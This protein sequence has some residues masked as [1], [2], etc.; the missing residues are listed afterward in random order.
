MA[1]LS[2]TIARLPL[3]LRKAGLLLWAGRLFVLDVVLRPL[4]VREIALQVRT[5]CEAR[6]KSHR[7]TRMLYN[8][9][10]VIELV[11]NQTPDKRGKYGPMQTEP[12]TIYVD[13][14]A[15]RAFNAAS[16]EERRKLEALLSLRLMEVARSKESLSEVMDE[17]S[18]KAQERG[19]TSETLQA[20]LS[21]D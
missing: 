15:A 10:E 12:I 21:E 18:R 1:T 5:D 7:V 17:I 16:D 6:A 11:A 3:D 13:P 14:A 2:C 19:L 4:V 8:T 20:I 9:S